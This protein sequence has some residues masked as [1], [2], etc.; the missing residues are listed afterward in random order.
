MYIIGWTSTVRFLLDQGADINCQT[1]AGRTPLMFAVQFS[2]TNLVIMLLGRKDIMLES[3][4]LEGFTALIVAI[5]MGAA[6]MD[7]AKL[8]LRAGADPNALTLRRKNPL[9]IACAAQNVEQVSLLLDFKVQRRNSAINLLRDEALVTVTRRLEE[10]ER[11]LQLEEEQAAAERE[12]LEKSGLYEASKASGGGLLGR[13][14]YGAW[15]EYRE[16]K[17]GKA[18]Y[19]NTVSRKCVRNKP[20]DFKP[21]KGRLIKEVIF[22]LSFY[23]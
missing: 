7:I 8:L 13:T 4:D 14:A 12:R 5:E 22:G 23:H 17:T 9:K 2:H 3:S 1:A 20:K 6:G 10:D 11:R 16:K 19:Y 15:V 21:N 18:F